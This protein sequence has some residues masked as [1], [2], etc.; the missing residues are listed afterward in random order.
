MVAIVHSS[1]LIDL[2]KNL[3]PGSFYLR[4]TFRLL[5]VTALQTHLGHF[6]LLS[7]SSSNC[8]FPTELD[9]FS[10]RMTVSYRTG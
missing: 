6:L 1:L 4:A 3:H 10:V 5:R 2:L 9:D 8:K 7:A